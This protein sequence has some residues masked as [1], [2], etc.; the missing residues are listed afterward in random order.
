MSTPSTQAPST[1]AA[2]L[3]TS[4][5]A[6]AVHRNA[7]GT[8]TMPGAY[9]RRELSGLGTSS[10]VIALTFDAGASAAGVNKILRT[11]KVKGVTAT[12][13]FT[14]KF[15]AAHSAT[16]KN[17]ASAYPIGNHSYSHPDLTTLSSSSVLKQV[18]DGEAAIVRASGGKKTVPFFRFPFGARDARVI[19]L[20]NSRCYV[21]FRWTID[22]LGWVGTKGTATI[23]AQSVASVRN[24]VL[25]KA[26][27]GGIVLMHVGDNPT[28]HSTLDADAL[29]SIIDGLRARGYRFV[30]LRRALGG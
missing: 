9:A 12:F 30:T 4:T 6:L 8:C 11:L 26:T 16:V 21:P 18:R 23:K 10:R 24:R 17:V 7:D 28:D 5:T 15:A 19:K 3:A 1:T 22:S 13:F 2:A 27:A 14:G 25:A 29:P 20:V